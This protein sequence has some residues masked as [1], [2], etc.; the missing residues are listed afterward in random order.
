MEE[1]LREGTD[2]VREGGEAP[3]DLREEQVH[4]EK[5]RACFRQKE[6]WQRPFGHLYPSFCRLFL[7]SAPV[8]PSLS[9]PQTPLGSS[10]RL[11]IPQALSASSLP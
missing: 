5:G 9:L 4:K 10:A 8:S 11:F 1:G 2:P 6:K 3:Q 7:H